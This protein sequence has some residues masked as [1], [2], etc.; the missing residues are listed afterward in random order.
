[1]PA[2][3][4]IP[5]DVPARP[6]PPAEGR[7]AASKHDAKAPS[8]PS[9]VALVPN[10]KVGRHLVYDRYPEAYDVL[11]SRHDCAG[12]LALL[13]AE[14]RRVAGL[15]EDAP[16][17]PTLR[18]A[19]LGCGTGRLALM[20]LP[21]ARRLFAADAAAPMVARCV[22][23][24]AAADAAL[25]PQL[26]GAPASGSE[27]HGRSA[28]MARCA[29][30]ELAALPNDVAAARGM[31]GGCP[32]AEC[33]RAAKADDGAATDGAPSKPRVIGPVAGYSVHPGAA[34]W[35][36][37]DMVVCGWSLSFVMTAQWGNTRWHDVV[38]RTVSAMVAALDASKGGVVCVVETLGNFSEA[39]VRRN[40]LHA[41]LANVLGFSQAWCRTDYVFTSAEEAR[42]LVTFFFGAKVA[43]RL[44]GTADPARL[45]ECTGVWVR[46]FGPGETV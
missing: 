14:A 37:L 32:C 28:V 8:L 36:G 41:Y 33:A 3:E 12:V 5:N 43:E 21:W 10:H 4:K 19:D 26:Y 29:F 18:I 17:A 20:L 7:E 30:E 42:R 24:V 27:E 40:S 44:A 9:D 34:G 25:R 1:M 31:D 39:P 46:R 45:L 35:G 22:E 15:R 38:F 11:M 16:P 23:R 6:Q 13:N 2:E